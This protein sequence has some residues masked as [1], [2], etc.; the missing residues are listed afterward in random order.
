MDRSQVGTYVKRHLQYAGAKNDIFSD[1]SLDEVFR[2]SSGAAHMVNKLFTHALLYGSQNGK[3]I[4]DDRMVKLVAD[5]E[6]A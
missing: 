5:G 6:V 4:I 3:R 1:A 2:L